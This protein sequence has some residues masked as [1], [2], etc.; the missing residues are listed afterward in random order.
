MLL[1]QDGWVTARVEGGELRLVSWTV[2]VKQVQ[3]QT[4]KYKNPGEGVVEHFLSER[5]AE[6]GEE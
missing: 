4:Q 3:A 6:W 2:A 5:R 1:D